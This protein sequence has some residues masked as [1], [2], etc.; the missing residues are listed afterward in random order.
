MNTV[1]RL[2]TADELFQMHGH[3]LRYE[4]VRGQLRTGILRGSKHGSLAVKLAS[5]L[6]QHVEAHALGEVFG[7]D[8][9]FKIADSPDTVRA[10]DVAFVRQERIPAGELTEK[11]WPGAPDLVAEVI[12]PSDTLY[13]LDEKIEEYLASGVAVVWVVNPKK[14]TVTVYRPGAGPGVL[15]EGDQLDGSPVL[16]AFQYPVAKLFEVKHR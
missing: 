4:L 1:P 10:P 15:S 7:P 3:G 11:F 12:S 14:R 6:F 9:G 2:T 5:S 16:P 8:T 13:E